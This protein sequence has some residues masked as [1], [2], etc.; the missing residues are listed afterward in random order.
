M[1]A[2]TTKIIAAM[3]ILFPV[4][5]AA[6]APKTNALTQINWVPVTGSGA[7]GGACAS[8][9][10]GQ[11]YTN[12]TNG[13]FYVCAS[14]GWVKVTGGGGGSGTVSGQ[15]SGV[16]GI[17]TGSTTTGAQSHINENTGGQ[18]TVTQALAVNDGSGKAGAV[19][20]AQGTTPT[21]AAAN[22]IQLDAPSS[23]TAYDV[24][25][26]GTHPSG[27]NTFLSCT[28]ANPS[29]CSWAAGGG[30]GGG[31]PTPFSYTFSVSG[32][33]VSAYD[34]NTNSSTP[35]A[36][37]TDA[38]VVIN[39]V[40]ALA[41]TT[42]AKLY[43]KNGTYNFNSATQETGLG[44]TNYYCVGIP[45]NN[46]NN[47]FYFQFEGESSQITGTV[48]STGGVV[49]KV[50]SAAVTAAGSSEL[51]AF[52]ARPSTGG[53]ATGGTA[54]MFKNLLVEFPDNT[55][56]KEVGINMLESYY[57]KL[58]NVGAGFIT[59]P[60]ALGAS[61]LKAYVTPA[62]PSN[63][64][65]FENV[66]AG[67]GWGVG[68]EDNTEHSVMSNVVA[69]QAT[70]CFVYGGEPN[71]TGSPIYH[72]SIWIHA[73][74][75]DCPHVMN[76]GAYI[77]AFSQLDLPN[78]DI[79]YINSGT[80][81]Y[82]DGI[83][84][85][86]NLG[87]FISWDNILTNVGR[88]SLTT[89]FASGSGT[90]YEVHNNGI[91][92]FPDII[93]NPQSSDPALATTDG[94]MWY[95]STT[96]TF[97]GRENGVNFSFQPS[98]LST[99]GDLYG[100][101]TGTTRIP[102]G[103]DGQTLQAD[104]TQAL[105]VKWANPALPYP[106][107]AAGPTL[108]PSPGTYATT[109]TVTSGSCPGSSTPYVSLGSTVVAGGTGVSVSS[110][111]TVYASCQGN[112]Y[113]TFT[114][115][116]Y[117]I[118]PSPYTVTNGKSTSGSGT[119]IAN[120]A[121]SATTTNPSFIVVV[122]SNGSSS[123][124]TYSVTDTAGNTYVD[125][126]PGVG[127]FGVSN[128]F[129]CFYAKNTS[130]TAS[131]VITGHSTTS[132][133]NFAIGAAEITG[134]NATTPIDGGSNV[135]YSTISTQTAGSGANTMT[136]TSLTPASNGDLIWAWFVSQGGALVGTSPNAFT[137]GIGAGGYGE[138]FYQVSSAA[139]AATAGSSGGGNIY[140]AIVLALKH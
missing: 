139:I 42:G 4:V 8:S 137:A 60:T 136:A 119:S 46:T 22:N 31:A 133:S 115:G 55:R 33:T 18:T 13:D 41:V 2:I 140:G 63:G 59:T 30:G 14:S 123:S 53:G 84:T 16:I 74:A 37:G 25:F 120:T 69:Y 80:W 91:A 51:D 82:V 6:A 87:G 77:S 39:T 97:R 128:A 27:S 88:G 71:H 17:A 76:V 38:A 26:P 29:V 34:N 44:Y 72:N 15:A 86:S 126:G 49:F 83:T 12:T 3:A 85:G 118:S 99:K 130:A 102:V 54:V 9:N 20:L 5:S 138:Y 132:V 68:F 57:E 73:Q 66:I 92:F 67:S 32:G 79:E 10:Y 45:N 103:S 62:T 129:Q 134:V 36:S 109:Q 40:M 56:G 19:S 135:G 101:S 121:F 114:N 52:W 58:E 112:G 21:A 23:V 106:P 75:Y 96:K 28:S 64:I 11:P 89:P 116:A 125:C 47:D 50:T 107:S 124:T 48:G 78:F 131:L 104:S 81:A 113:L 100:Y 111:G 117:T 61:T 24:V 105:G 98:L 95:N 35:V 93:L 127:Q 1:R 110:S 122:L 108:S 7:P 90:S 94:W 43:F 70:T 65:Y